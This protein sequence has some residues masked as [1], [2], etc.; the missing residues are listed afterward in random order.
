MMTPGTLIAGSLL[1]DCCLCQRGPVAAAASPRPCS[2]AKG[3]EE[4]FWKTS[5]WLGEA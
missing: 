1:A 4:A 3:S 5:I 2:E